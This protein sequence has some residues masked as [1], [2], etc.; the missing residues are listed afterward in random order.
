[1]LFQLYHMV[2]ISGWCWLGDESVGGDGSLD[3]RL[4]LIISMTTEQTP[5]ADEGYV[6]WLTAIKKKADQ[7]TLILDFQTA[8]SKVKNYRYAFES[9]YE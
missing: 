5:F 2:F 8:I 1:M 6:I 9:C 7:M 4:D 3:M